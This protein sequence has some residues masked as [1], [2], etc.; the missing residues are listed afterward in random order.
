[1]GRHL[2]IEMIDTEWSTDINLKKNA[3]LSKYSTV[4][5]LQEQTEASYDEND[6]KLIQLHLTE[7]KNF[8]RRKYK[9]SRILSYAMKNSISLHN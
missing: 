5:L 1:M 3:R 9:P 7:K 8:V 6:T 2:Q 4:I